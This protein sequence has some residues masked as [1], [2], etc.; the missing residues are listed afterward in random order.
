MENQR[1]PSDAERFFKDMPVELQLRAI[2]QLERQKKP[3]DTV[4]RLYETQQREWERVK[5]DRAESEGDLKS[6][7]YA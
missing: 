6:R 1:K 7:S 3:P 5:A 4:R 2:Q